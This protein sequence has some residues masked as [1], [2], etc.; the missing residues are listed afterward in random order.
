MRNQKAKIL[1]NFSLEQVDEKSPKKIAIRLYL[2]RFCQSTK[3]QKR[4][5]ISHNMRYGETEGK[6]RK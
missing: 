5:N 1:F 6:S 4:Q 2:D 3:E